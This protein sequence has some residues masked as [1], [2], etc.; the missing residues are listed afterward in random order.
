MLIL[1]RRI[2]RQVAGMAVSPLLYLITFG[3]PWAG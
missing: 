1:K 3:Y 2:G